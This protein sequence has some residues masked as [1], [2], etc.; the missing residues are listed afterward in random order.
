MLALFLALAGGC[1]PFA[2]VQKADTIDA[3]EAYLRDHPDSPNVLQAEGRLATLSLEKARKDG[4]VESYDAFLARF[5]K[6]SLVKDAQKERKD[7]VWA[8]AD[9]EDTVAAWKGIV[10]EFSKP[11]KEGGDRDMVKRAKRR[12]RMATHKDA[13]EISPVEMEMVNLAENPDGE[14]NGYGFFADVKNVGTKPIVMLKLRIQYLDGSGDAVGEAE[15]PVV[16]TAL[17]GN[18]P[19]AEGFDKPIAPGETR[20]WEW[21]TGDMP[22]GWAKKSKLTAVDIRV[23]GDKD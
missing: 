3:Y 1:D 16:A 20:R 2:D 17:P 4:T 7:L 18:M 10:D 5:P 8:R 15:W 11:D 9:A 22:D 6:S 23:E 12:M 21:T 13:V 19:M 14:L